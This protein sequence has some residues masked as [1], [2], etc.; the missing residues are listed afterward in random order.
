MCINT[1]ISYPVLRAGSFW[2]V[3][4]F[5]NIDLKKGGISIFLRALAL[6]TYSPTECIN[7]VRGRCRAIGSEMR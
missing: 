3:F 2:R 5:T 6:Q 4:N 1:L 7:T